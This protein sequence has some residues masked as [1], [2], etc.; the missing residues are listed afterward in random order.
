MARDS[1]GEYY[2]VIFE[3]LTMICTR[4]FDFKECNWGL[5]FRYVFPFTPRSNDGSATSVAIALPLNNGD[6]DATRDAIYVR[7]IVN[8][9]ARVV[10]FKD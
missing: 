5:T 10:V 6:R 2:L 4:R 3:V 9:S 1:F 7:T 8:F